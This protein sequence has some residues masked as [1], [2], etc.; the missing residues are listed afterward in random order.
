MT[1]TQL[2][3]LSRATGVVSVLAMTLVVLLGTATTARSA[4]RVHNR[5][6]ITA[7]HRS[8]A[9]GLSLFL[10]V[11]IATAILTEFVDI[12]WLSVVAPFTAGYEPLWVGFG[13]VAVDLLCAVVGTSL[14]RHRLSQRA[15]RRV[16]WLT[17]LLWPM[18]I[19]HAVGMSTS[20]EP[21]LMGIT[22]G[23]AG[24]GLLGIAHRLFTRDAD[25]RRRALV[26][27]GEW[28]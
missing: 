3:F 19:L 10:G 8:L 27:A 6:L 16:H 17:Y 2:W 15:W 7:L 14:L 21:I 20:K 4:R 11:H 13:S 1:H 12:D 22:V 9:L 18:A 24:A 26:T 25:T 28:S 5:A 23:C